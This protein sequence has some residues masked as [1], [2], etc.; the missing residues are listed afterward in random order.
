[1]HLT[2]YFLQYKDLHTKI[3]TVWK[4]LWTFLGTQK[5]TVPAKKWTGSCV[6]LRVAMET[7]LLEDNAILR[8]NLITLS[9][10]TVIGLYSQTW[11]TTAKRPWLLGQKRWTLLNIST[12]RWTRDVPRRRGLS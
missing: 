2:L 7:S 6:M 1:M 8:G 9:V 12:F 11:R 10:S 3:A 4:S 5:L